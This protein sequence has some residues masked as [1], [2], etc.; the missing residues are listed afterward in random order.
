M[1]IF[2]TGG[3]GFIGSRLVP[4]L[5]ARGH[6][7]L[8]LTRKVPK[9]SLGRASSVVGDLSNQNAWREDLKKFK[10]DAVIHLAW[11]GLENY[12]FEARVSLANMKNSL[13]LVSLAAELRCKKFLSL[14]SCWE[15][16]GGEGPKKESDTLNPPS[17]IP[18][19]VFAKRA[20][21]TMGEQIA[22]ESKMQFLWARLFFVYGPRQ[23][24]RTLIA[25]LV[26]NIKVGTAPEIK[27]KSGANDFVFIDDVADAL[28]NILENSKEQSAI[29]NVGSGRLTG[30]GEVVKEVY[31]DFN[32][33]APKW[34]FKKTTPRGFYAN[35]LK[36]KKEIGWR[37]RTSMA[38]GIKKTILHSK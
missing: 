14:G 23:K 20:I 8:F 18:S 24:P 26:K 15:Y 38:E 16:G 4:K 17:H 36:I 37:P 35:I 21:Q 28:L 9:K 11:E 31:K 5:L 30:V 1:R 10:P 2:I 25:H 34:C 12:D 6:K 3:T 32:I 13:D 27:N 7:L 33:L 22:M 19:F 29:Y